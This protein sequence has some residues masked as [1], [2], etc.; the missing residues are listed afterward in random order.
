MSKTCLFPWER[1]ASA[2]ASVLTNANKIW[3]SNVLSGANETFKFL[4]FLQLRIFIITSHTGM[5]YWGVYGMSNRKILLY[6]NITVFNKTMNTLKFSKKSSYNIRT[7]ENT[8]QFYSIRTSKNT[9]NMETIRTCVEWMKKYSY[10]RSGTVPYN[11]DFDFK[12]LWF[13]LISLLVII[14]LGLQSFFL[15]KKACS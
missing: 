14:E 3:I 12:F 10:L 9:G 15:V 11:F 7:Y 5:Q 2:N 13:C 1:N 4:V 8:R 6:S